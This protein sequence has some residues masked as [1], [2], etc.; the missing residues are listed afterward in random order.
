DLSEKFR[1]RAE[2]FASIGNREVLKLIGKNYGVGGEKKPEGRDAE[3]KQVLERTRQRYFR[4]E[5]NI[6]AG[7][8]VRKLLRFRIELVDII[9]IAIGVLLA[10]IVYLFEYDFVSAG[11]TAAFFGIIIGAVDLLLRGR[12]P[13][14]PKVLGFIAAGVVLY[15]YGYY[16]R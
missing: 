8:R 15:V 1:A 6:G 7:E 4:P 14:F 9:D 12:D 5:D 10:G 16:F 2:L 11:I 13:F 3:R